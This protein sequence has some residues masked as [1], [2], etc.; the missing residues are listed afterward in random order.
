MALALPG[1]PPGLETS[2]KLPLLLSQRGGCRYSSF[3]RRCFAT[4]G[5]SCLHRI[6]KLVSAS[7]SDFAGT[8]AESAPLVSKYKRFF[9]GSDLFSLGLGGVILARF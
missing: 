1:R 3:A 4:G 7:A 9:E 5:N 2:K 8:A 6:M